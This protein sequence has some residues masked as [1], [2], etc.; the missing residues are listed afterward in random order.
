MEGHDIMNL[1][2][3]FAFIMMFGGCYALWNYAEDPLIQAAGLFLFMGF[4][5]S[6]VDDLRKDN[7]IN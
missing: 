5:L 7:K 2:I 3:I 4:C 1:L 6:G